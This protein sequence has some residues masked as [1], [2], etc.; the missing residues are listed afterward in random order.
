M[1]VGRAATASGLDAFGDELDDF[2]E[3]FAREPF[4][5]RS[6]A[7]QIE[8]LALL[9]RLRRAGSDDL[10]GEDVERGFGR[11]QAV[12]LAVADPAQESRAFDE[13]VAGERIQPALRC[14]AAEVTGATD[15][16][17]EGREAAG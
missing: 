8:E 3:D 9:P 2:V 1:E 15:A 5:G 10:L 6:A 4:E 16:L 7:A 17:E 11:Q 14:P 13:F 12:E